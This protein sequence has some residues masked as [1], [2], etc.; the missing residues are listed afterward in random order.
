MVRALRYTMVTIHDQT[1]SPASLAQWQ[2][3]LDA[4]GGEARLR[5]EAGPAFRFKDEVKV[6]ISFDYHGQ[7]RDGL[8]IGKRRH[9]A[10][11]TDQLAIE[12]TQTGG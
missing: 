7:H 1:H 6:W 10:R 3:I 2:N 8:V 5:V 9:P 4:K 12:R 11:Q